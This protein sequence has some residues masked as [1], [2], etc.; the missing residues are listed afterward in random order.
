MRTLNENFSYDRSKVRTRTSPL[1][2]LWMDY[3][4]SQCRLTLS[5]TKNC[6]GSV[7]NHHM[8]FVVGVITV[9]VLQRTLNAV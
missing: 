7:V 5:D 9:I 2:G 4:L 1:N 8:I 3:A 6:G